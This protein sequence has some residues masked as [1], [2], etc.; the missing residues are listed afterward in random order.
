MKLVYFFNKRKIV[1]MFYDVAA[2][3]VNDDQ[4]RVWYQQSSSLLKI[5][6]FFYELLLFDDKTAIRYF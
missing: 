1:L 5:L 2:E 4:V 6:Q 3:A